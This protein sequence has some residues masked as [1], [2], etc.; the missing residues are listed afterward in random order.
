LLQGKPV[1]TFNNISPENY[2]INID[3]PEKL[4]ESV[5][6]T[7]QQPKCLMYNI[8]HYIDCTHLYVDGK[9]SYRL[10][11]AIDKRLLKKPAL[12]LSRLMC[13]GNLKCKKN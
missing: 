8:Q 2:L 9:S 4:E 1:V 7:L 5:A 3:S 11:A 12:K 13:S 10:L 6:Y